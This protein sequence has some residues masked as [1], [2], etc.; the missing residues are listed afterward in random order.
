MLIAHLI[1]AQAQFT[2]S[3]HLKDGS[4]GEDLIGATVN[5]SGTTTGSSANF[6]GFYSLTLPAGEYTLLYRY[7]GYAPLERKVVL[8]K[9]I[10]LDIEL[11]DAATDLKEVEVT[12]RA[13]DANVQDV[14][15]SVT[16]MSME[17]IK[18]LPAFMGEVDV[19]KALQ[20][21]PG[22][23]TTGEGG[24][25]LYVRGGNV[26]QNLILLDEAP[27]YNA[28]HLMGFF[29]VFNGDAIKD[30][31]LYKG[32]IPAEYGGRLSSVVDI[33]MK[34]GNAKRFSAEGGVGTI[35][36]RLTLQA[37]IKK[38]K[39]SFII[40]GRRTYADLFLKF[41]ADEVR[42]NSALYFYDLNAKGNYTLGAKDR[43]FL[44][45]YFGRDVFKTEGFN[46]NWGN[47]TVTGRWNHIYN[48]RLFSNLTVF[49]SDFDYALGSDDETTAFSWNSKIRNLSGKLD[50]N[51]YVNSSNSLKFGYQLI[52]HTFVP[53]IISGES[54]ESV[55]TGLELQNS[56]ALEHGVYVS[57]EQRIG[58]RITATYGLRGSMFQNIGAHDVYGYDAGNNVRDTTAYGTGEVYNTYMNL[59]PR[60]G[61]RYALNEVSSVKL[62]Y[63]RMAQY[64]HL[65]SNGN[66]ATP[67]DIWF[68][69]SPNVKPELADQVAGGYF[70][71]FHEN[72]WEASMEVYYKDM[73]NAIDFRDHAQLFFNDNLEGELRF[74]HAWSYGAEFLVRKQEGRFTG[75]LSYTLSRA[76]R[77]IEGINDGR[78]YRAKYD[79]THNVS[80]TGSYELNKLW[81]VGALWVYQTGGAA[82]FPVGRYEYGGQIVPIYSERNAARL[83]A[84][85]RF[86]F[87]I[88]K[89]SRKNE[90]RRW[91]S[92][93]VLSVYNAYLRHNTYS[94]N[95]RQDEDDPFT[96]YAEKTYLFSIVPSITYNFK[97]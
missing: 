55:V 69:S 29:S 76:E 77:K 27:V 66:Q 4:T 41:S 53:G 61:L 71:N 80:I 72:R 89:A 84:Y 51:Y 45:G 19:I 30:V 18:T 75:M 35:A 6:Y 95:F 24:S 79:K 62:S 47:A 78:T 56:R 25:G 40:S 91:Q 32:G 87:S 48:S 36:S 44:S 11:S 59:E 17:Q 83:P 12:G 86:D 5:V 70:R 50:Y 97:F 93:W 37:P 68:P 16:R 22:V 38:D 58:T 60:L 74:G 46:V 33:R 42:R 54:E 21:L 52:R 2:V 49:Y 63:N 13:K 82:T 39:G 81:R 20:L 14:Q 94:I 64:I 43:V 90:G 9:D 1:V 15:M 57:N 85:H 73:T 67:F 88:T 7:I 96:T 8:D 31:Q 65:A 23:Q 3:G 34:D 92:E 10:V 28:S 26:D